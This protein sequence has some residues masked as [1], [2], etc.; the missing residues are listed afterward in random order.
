MAG[1]QRRVAAVLES[2]GSAEDV[3]IYADLDEVQRLLGKP[4]GV[5]LIEVSAW[6]SSCPTWLRSSG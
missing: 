2:T 1:V 4:D 6:C 3:A 5:S